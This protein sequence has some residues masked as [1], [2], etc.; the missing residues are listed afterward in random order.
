MGKDSFSLDKF[1]DS[2]ELSFAYL[3][4]ELVKA[5]VGIKPFL[6]ITSLNEKAETGQACG[7]LN[8]TSL[9]EP[10]RKNA[11]ICGRFALLSFT[12]SHYGLDPGSIILREN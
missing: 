2:P 8:F 11:H 5:D 9:Y 7:H 4:V 6:T 3:S 12:H 10:G 1:K